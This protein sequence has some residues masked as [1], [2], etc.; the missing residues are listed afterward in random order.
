MKEIDRLRER[1]KEEKEMNQK[2][3]K[4]F[5]EK[6]KQIL[7]ELDIMEERVKDLMYIGDLDERKQYYYNKKTIEK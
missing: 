5:R 7:K 3:R 6:K 1:L 2:L 4:R